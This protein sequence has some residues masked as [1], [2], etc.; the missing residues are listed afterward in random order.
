MDKEGMGIV[1]VVVAGVVGMALVIKVGVEANTALVIG[2]GVVDKKGV[3]SVVG[4]G[5]VG[6][7]LVM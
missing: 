5:V 1:L 2:A 6:T 7:A 4:T 3:V